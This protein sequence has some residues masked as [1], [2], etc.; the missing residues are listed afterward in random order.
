ML[1]DA[2]IRLARKGFDFANYQYT[3]MG[4]IYFV[5]FILFHK[6]LGIRKM[7][8]YEMSESVKQRVR[9]NRPFK[10]IQLRFA[11]IGDAIPELDQDL[12]H[13]LWLDYDFP[14]NDIVVKDAAA[15]GAKLPRR[16][17]LLITVDAEPPIKDDERARTTSRYFKE[18]V[19]NLLDSSWRTK[20]FVPSN[21]DKINVTLLERAIRHGLVGRTNIR[22]LPLFNFTYADGHRM[23]T[24][25][26]ILGGDEEERDINGCDFSDAQYIRRTL[27][28]DPYHIP[29]IQLT[30]KERAYL[31]TEM[32]ALPNWKL[33]RFELDDSIVRAYKE[34][35]RFFPSYAELLV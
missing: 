18:E 6:L 1:V 29:R 11:P 7:W 21:L 15:A 10:H 20:D 32:P 28:I 33:K 14:L 13:I 25:G 12:L 24:I 3:G 22:F 35:Y 19:P 5:D 9:F 8:S 26:G 2:L 23:L 16:S 17:L 4:S 31:D 27:D 34:V 30:R